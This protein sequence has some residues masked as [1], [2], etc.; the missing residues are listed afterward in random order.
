MIVI[1]HKNNK[2]LEIDHKGENLDFLETSIGDTLLKIAVAYPEKLLIWC[3][4]DFK[5]NLNYSKIQDIFHHHKIM[6]SYNLSENFF[7]S[8]AIGYVEGSPFINVN[9]KVSY[10]T[11]LM[12]STIGGVH[13]SVLVALKEELIKTYDFDYFLNS[14]AK[15]V[16]PN[17]LLCYSEPQLVNDIP[18]KIRKHKNSLFVLFRFVKQHYKTRWLFLL[19]LNLFLYERKLAVL[20]F[21][22][23]FFYSK[24]K[25]KKN[26]LDEI[27]VQSTKKVLN[28]GTVDVIIPTIGRAKYLYDVLCDLRNQ[29]HLPRK[30]I[31]VEQ[32]PLEGSVSELDYLARETWP[33]E[34]KHIFTHQAGACNARNLAL[35]EVESEWVF[36]NDDDNRFNKGIIEQTLNSCVQFGTKVTSN[37]Y[38]TINDTKTMTKVYQAPFFGSG[39]SF[40]ASE[41]L[42]KVSFRMGFEFG[43]GEDSDFGMQLRNSGA[44]VLFFPEP[45][46][47]HLKAPIGGF[48]TKPILEWGN[49]MI[50]PKPSPTIMLYKQLHLTKEQINGYK[51]ILFFKFYKNQT[52]K[53]PIRYF[54]NFQKRW[55]QSLYWADELKNRK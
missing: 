15:L 14:I 2:V 26:L 37:S 36:L 17:G 8:E 18:N 44:D 3:C 42:E 55:N 52:I 43:Y 45:E 23:S 4:I 9:K 34:I 47:L 24:R 6:A 32:N 5:T 31:I 35:N 54:S 30:I 29:T 51:T 11:W 19:L 10:P 38:L 53:N 48:R 21:L 27:E 33:F 25:F 7:L 50:Q 12:S 22:F 41:L 20:P 13:A 1:Y 46:I 39:N 28:T 49:D 16:M 40:I